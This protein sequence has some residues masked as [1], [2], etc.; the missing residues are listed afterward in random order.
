MRNGKGSSRRPMLVSQKQF[1]KNWK[2]AFQIK[3][4]S[5][6]CKTK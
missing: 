5:K 2:K 1:D 3:K 4:H 6:S